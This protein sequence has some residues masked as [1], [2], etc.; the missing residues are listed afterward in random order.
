MEIPGA[1][2]ITFSGFG[3]LEAFVFLLKATFFATP[4]RPKKP[5]NNACDFDGPLLKLC[6]GTVSGCAFMPV[7]YDI[8]EVISHNKG[9]R[10]S[11]GTVSCHPGK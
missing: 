2:Q 8:Q 1:A 4:P 6:R 9:L 7:Q 11:H 10:D 5:E 3:L